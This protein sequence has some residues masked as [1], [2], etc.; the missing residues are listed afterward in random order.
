MACPSQSHLNERA[1]NFQNGLYARTFTDAAG[2]MGQTQLALGYEA[3]GAIHLR[4]FV[5]FNQSDLYPVDATALPQGGSYTG[6]GRFG[7]E[8]NCTLSATAK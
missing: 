4:G 2:R 7:Q 6:V 3:G 8:A 5:A 1:A